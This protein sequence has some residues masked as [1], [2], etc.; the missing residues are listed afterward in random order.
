MSRKIYTL[1]LILLPIFLQAQEDSVILRDANITDQLELYLEQWDGE[2]E[3]SEELVE[4]LY[5]ERMDKKINLNALSHEEAVKKLQLT[6][7]QYYQL[8]LYIEEHGQLVTVHELAAIEGFTSGDVAR[9]L[10]RVEAHPTKERQN[11]FHGFFHKSKSSLLIRYGQILEPQVGYDTARGNHYPGSPG[12]ACFRFSFNSQDK[13]ILRLSGEKDAGEQFFR[14][15]QK[16]GFDFYAGSLCVQDMGVLRRAVVGDYRLNFGQGLVL[17]SSL[18]SGRG[19]GVE[20]ARRFGSGIRAAAPTNEGDFLRGGAV[21]I[22]NSHIAG[23]LFGG[24]AYGS[25]NNRFGADLSYRRAVFKVGV[26][27]VLLSATDTL[28]GER[29]R[30][31]FTPTGFNVAA[32]YHLIAKRHLLFGEA[33]INQSGKLALLQAAKLNLSPVVKMLLLFRHYDRGF[34]APLGNCFGVSSRN[35]GETGLYIATDY[36]AGRNCEVSLFADYYFLSEPSYRTDAPISG[37]DCGISVV[38]RIGRHGQLLGKYS[39]RT[40]PQNGGE[41]PY[42]HELAERQRHKVRLQW[43][44]VPHPLVKLKTELDWQLQRDG[45][46]RNH[47]QGL[48]LYQD[49]AVDMTRIGL[50]LHV[51]IAYF[52][53][54]RYDERLYAY[55][56]DLYYA[57]TIGSYYYKGIRGYLMLRYKHKWCSIWLRLARTHYI[58]RQ[59]IGG[60][61]NQIHAPHKT[62]IKAQI[63]FS[64]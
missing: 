31:T 56:N 63:M 24:R 49:V 57:F 53:T 21:T 39:W 18:L 62:E 32:D 37:L 45:D 59:T 33:A 2:S 50:S 19:G 29:L 41:N 27:A 23:T 4:E 12:H 14:G 60:G 52:D 47:Y 38:Y 42:L 8:Q 10:P 26:R 48:L 9:L 46:T 7:Y 11:F 28:Q 22:G 61:L 34:S 54:D 13:V 51:R 16:Q 20:S 43:S 36:I 64:I 25:L 30:S 44:F 55:E 3:L 1:I 15:E 6:D 17:G 35:S 5:E 58:D 40:R